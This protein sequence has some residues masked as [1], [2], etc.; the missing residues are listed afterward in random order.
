MYINEQTYVY[1]EHHTDNNSCLRIPNKVNTPEEAELIVVSGYMFGDHQLKQVTEFINTWA[2]TKPIYID[3]TTEII[4]K[5][6]IK[7]LLDISNL[8]N[9][10]LLCSPH[11][12]NWM[13]IELSL[14]Q[15]R[16]LQIKYDYYFL[17]YM[18]Y[19][20]P[21]KK[22]IQVPNK[23][24]LMMIGKN[25]WQRILLLSLLSH[26]N[27]LE[28]GH[29]SYVGNSKKTIE[30]SKNKPDEIF[31]KHIISNCPP[32]IAKNIKNGY[33]KITTPMVLDTNYIDY[34]ISHTRKYNA[35]YYDAVEFVVVLESNFIHEHTY[36]PTEKVSKCIQ[37]NKKMIVFGT[38]YFVKNTIDF[39]K[40]IGIDISNLFNW[41]DMSYDDIPNVFDRAN[42]ISKIIEDNI[43]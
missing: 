9:I 1:L 30:F 40:T 38:Q 11:E 27:L 14:L 19:Y 42:K 6:H 23:K 26:K 8:Y 15:S 25:K 37:L 43:V 17:R 3:A 22:S 39:Y 29:V 24:Y 16:G 5:N 12:P 18:N 21:Y 13:N 7:S 33:K 41:C 4:V 34:K 32:I 35:T 31:N 28:Y 2:E 10:T 36:F 20:T